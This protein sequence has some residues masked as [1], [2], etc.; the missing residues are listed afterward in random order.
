MA[1]MISRRSVVLSLAGLAGLAILAF[2]AP[3]HPLD[4][5]SWRS[6]PPVRSMP[7]FAHAGDEADG[8]VAYRSEPG[9][10]LQKLVHE[11]I[12]D[13]VMAY[14]TNCSR[15]ICRLSRSTHI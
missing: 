2:F 10:D 13:T 9:L 14:P 1:A 6:A 11:D 12:G 8:L 3:A 5:L 4:A 15:A 7:V